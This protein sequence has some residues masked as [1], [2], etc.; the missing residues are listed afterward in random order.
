MG[1]IDWHYQQ[2][3]L[4]NLTQPFSSLNQELE[5]TNKAVLAKVALWLSALYLSV[6]EGR[7]TSSTT[8][9]MWNMCEEMWK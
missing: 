1:L 6:N 4:I 3:G 7:I 9:S 2:E 8:A 5:R